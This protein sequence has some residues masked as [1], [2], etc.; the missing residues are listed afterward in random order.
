MRLRGLSENVVRI[1]VGCQPQISES[2]SL[3]LCVDEAV[4]YPLPYLM[5]WLP[6]AIVIIALPGEA[7]NLSVYSV[8]LNLWD[9]IESQLL[10]IVVDLQ[11]KSYPGI[12]FN[13]LMTLGLFFV[14]KR[15]L[16]FAIGM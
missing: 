7:F 13:F 11:F 1:F 9:M 16:N 8:P 15:R 14:R 3:A 6:T 5:K 12:V 2:L 10:L 4:R